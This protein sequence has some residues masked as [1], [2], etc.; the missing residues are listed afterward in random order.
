MPRRE[1]V[2]ALGARL[3]AKWTVDAE[4]GY[5]P[6][7][8]EKPQMVVWGRLGGVEGGDD[9]P[10]LWDRSGSPSRRSWRGSLSSSYLWRTQ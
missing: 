3:M 1:P 10:T 9:W 2:M 4:R 6:L 8:N 7:R 5:G